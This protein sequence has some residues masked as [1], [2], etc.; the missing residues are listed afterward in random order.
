MNYVILF[1][2]LIQYALSDETQKLCEGVVVTSEKKIKFDEMETKLLCGDKSDPAWKEIPP[3]QAKVFMTGFLQSRAY[4][5]PKYEIKNNTLYVDIGKEHTVEELLV[6]PQSLIEAKELEKDVWHIYKNRPITPSLLNSAQSSSVG[7]LRERSYPCVKFNAVTNTNNGI[8]VLNGENLIRHTFGKTKTEEVENLFSTAFDRFYPYAPNQPFDARKLKLAEKRF[9]RAGVVESSY[10]IEECTETAEEF[11]LDH[12]LIVGPPRVFGFGIGISTEVGPMFRLRWANNRLGPMASQLEASV[13]AD[14][15]YQTIR[16]YAD[17]YIWED[18]PRTSAES[19]LKIGRELQ[20]NYEETSTKVYAGL[21][22]TYDSWNRLYT[23]A[24]GPALWAGSFITDNDRSESGSYE[25]ISV[26]GRLESMSHRYEFYDFLPE[27]GSWFRLKLDYR[28]KQFGFDQDHF[29]I[30]TQH[31]ALGKMF[32]WGRGDA[33]GGVRVGAHTTVVHGASV[34]EDIPPSMKFYG[35][36][37]DDIRGF[38]YRQLP[39]N[40]GLGA[41]TK[42]LLKLELRKTHLYIPG[43]EWFAFYDAAVFGFDSWELSERIRQSPGTGIRWVSPVGLLQSFVARGTSTNPYED[44]DYVVFVG[45]G[46]EF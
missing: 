24:L 34:I 16:L 21:K 3:Y 13:E 39:E 29:K 4:L 43:L 44:D 8:I 33:V 45:L 19:L 32:K 42:L 6:T 18:Y 35:G 31:T 20:V 46:G 23:F 27:E 15:R 26:E 14:L 11:G 2:I 36:G 10:F 41:L 30:S 12:E 37:S 1:L 40:N 25:G 5:T 38:G 7:F 17:N 28:P 9:K 22:K